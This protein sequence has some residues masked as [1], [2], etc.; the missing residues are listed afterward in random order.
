MTSVEQASGFPGAA[1]LIGPHVGVWAYMTSTTA[2][3]VT[4]STS[5]SP[6]PS[7]PFFLFFFFSKYTATDLVKGDVVNFTIAADAA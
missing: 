3:S 5:P 4:V 6:F 1:G 2:V 7:F